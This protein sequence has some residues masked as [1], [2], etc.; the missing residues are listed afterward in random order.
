MK[1]SFFHLPHFLEQYK[2]VEKIYHADESLASSMLYDLYMTLTAEEMR[3]LGHKPKDMIKECM[4]EGQNHTICKEFMENGGTEIYVPKFGVCHVL[5]FKGLN[6]SDGNE[7]LKVKNAGSD[8][9]LKLI[10][11]IQSEL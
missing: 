6:D 3:E 9:G 2:E 1:N 8:H 10:L 5:N 4:F 7:E 11:D